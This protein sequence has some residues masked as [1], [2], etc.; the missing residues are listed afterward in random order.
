MPN[1][2][3]E[4]AKKYDA[5]F[6]PASL[7]IVIERG[8]GVELIGADGHRTLDLGDIIANVGHS[9]PR[10]VQAIH[11]AAANMIVGKGSWTN[12]E[13]ARLMQR[14]VEDRKSVV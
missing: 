12:P 9:H 11:H 8:E 7:P 6:I 14:L 5:D 2:F 10:L 3:W 13:R 1:E 4:L